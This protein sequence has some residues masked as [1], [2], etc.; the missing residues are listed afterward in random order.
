MN[1]SFS[2]RVLIIV[3]TWDSRDRKV[4]IEGWKENTEIQDVEFVWVNP[5]HTSLDSV[6]E[7]FRNV[8]FLTYEELYKT[9]DT[10]EHKNEKHT[11]KQKNIR[12]E[13]FLDRHF[14]EGR[15]D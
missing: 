3:N 2:Q 6:N 7:K 12:R 5:V 13:D 14:C 4:S 15:H 8:N 9:Y 11:N 10:Y 1:L